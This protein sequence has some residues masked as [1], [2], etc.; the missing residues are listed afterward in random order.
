[1]L[2]ERTLKKRIIEKFF[3]GKA[4]II[5]GARQVGK[6]T[7]L[8][9]I[10]EELKEKILW[11][12]ADEPD[13][14]AMFEEA[15]SLKIKQIIGNYKIVFIDEAQRI[16]NIGIII[17]LIVDN[18][19]DIQI[20][21]TGSSSLGLFDKIKEPLTGRKYQFTLYP[22]SFEEITNHFGYIESLRMLD[23]I[24]TYGMYP[25]I[26]VKSSES[27]N[28]LTQLIDSYLYKDLLMYEGIKKHHLI[29]K[30]LQAISLQVGSEVSYNEVAQ[31]VGANKETVEKYI[32]L[33]EDC[34]ILFKLNSLSR[35]MRNEIKK[36]KKIYFQDIGVRNALIS[37][38]SSIPLR[39]DIGA[40]W[41]NFII[42]ERIKFLQNHNLYFNIYFWRVVNGRE[43]DYIEEID[44]KIYAY[45][46]KW[47]PKAK[48]SLPRG[49]MKNYKIEEFKI[50]NKDNFIDFITK[51]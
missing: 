21:A 23:F 50:I 30:L 35:N 31:L 33:L 49:L 17:K 10:A 27:K 44:G 46:I 18:L 41:E 14:R 8:K 1:M 26:V 32:Y 42:S 38:F 19:P 40:L 51:R 39:T 7:L 20:V 11:L 24:L 29:F 45:E 5:Y 37:N 12:N 47:N 22:L 48:T 34:F 6:T 43:V 2:I 16:T 3:K 9:T 13:I 4:I 28:L 15:T 25:E 36:G